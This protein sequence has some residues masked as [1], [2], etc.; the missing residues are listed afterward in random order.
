MITDIIQ[1]GLFIEDL[2]ANAERSLN[3]SKVFPEKT[4]NGLPEFLTEIQHERRIDKHQMAFRGRSPFVEFLPFPHQVRTYYAQ[5][6]NQQVD[7]FIPENSELMEIDAPSG[8]YFYLGKNK[9]SP[10][11]DLNN[12]DGSPSQDFLVSPTG[13]KFWVKNISHLYL[14][15]PTLGDA[16]S[17]SFWGDL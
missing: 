6:A 12:T 13:K 5:S 3:D 10:I 7:V 9:I 1:D 14:F 11:T 8:T 4:D 15:I 16:V 2:V 17:F